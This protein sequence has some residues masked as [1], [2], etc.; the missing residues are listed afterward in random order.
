[1]P[2]PDPGAERFF[3]R[4]QASPVLKKMQEASIELNFSAATSLSVDLVGVKRKGAALSG[5]KC[6][7][8]PGK[9]LRLKYHYNK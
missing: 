4:N 8:A 9:S 5:S 3:P 6:L 1:M 2:V 7:T